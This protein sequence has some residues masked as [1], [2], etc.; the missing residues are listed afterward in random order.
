MKMFSEVYCSMLNKDWSTIKE[1]L[2]GGN[3]SNLLAGVLRY[4]FRMRGH[5]GAKVMERDWDYLIILDACRY[6]YFEEIYEEYLEGNLEKMESAGTTSIEFLNKNFTDYYDDTV[7]VSAN[8]FVNPHEI[9]RANF[10]EENF[11]SSKHFYK[12]YPVF[13]DTEDVVKPR[14]LKE[15]AFKS[16]ENHPH[17]KIIIHFMQPHTPYIGDY[18][19][20]DEQ[21]GHHEKMLNKGFS[22]KE[23]RKAYKSNLEI[24]LKHV[25]DLVESLNG[26]IIITADHGEF[27]GEY[28]L[29]MHPH[30]I[31]MKELTE[32][33]W[34]EIEN[35]ERPEI[36]SGVIQDIEY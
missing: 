24:V 4:Y 19:L 26:E 34:L 27:L 20:S 6:D 31:Y 9:H 2:R 13:L 15:K 35:G 17:K 21:I 23:I 22:W 25:K 29:S 16:V 7:Y 1:N 3:Y 18:S 5:E 10:Q 32:V 8:A 11:N 14:E 12:V 33:P 28:G 30:S 36:G